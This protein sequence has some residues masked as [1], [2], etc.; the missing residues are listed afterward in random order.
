[1][2]NDQYI[3]VGCIGRSQIISMIR[4]FD[5]CQPD[6]WRFVGQ[7]VLI[8]GCLSDESMN[9]D[10]VKNIQ[11]MFWYSNQG[12]WIENNGLRLEYDIRG[13]VIYSL[14]ISTIDG[15]VLVKC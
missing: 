9:V 12:T 3:L 8:P 1:M 13:D 14:I 2:N 10:I 6:F 4:V 11:S 15:E 5:A 7:D